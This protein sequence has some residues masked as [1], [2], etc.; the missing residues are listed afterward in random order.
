MFLDIH[1]N[2]VVVVTCTN[3]RLLVIYLREFSAGVRGNSCNCPTAK[4]CRPDCFVNASTEE[5][6]FGRRFTSIQSS[7]RLD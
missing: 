5:L 2:G 1:V 6:E 3:G 7:I 4:D